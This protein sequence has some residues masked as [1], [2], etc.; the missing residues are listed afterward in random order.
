LA[1][2][3]TRGETLSS[4]AKPRDLC[5]AAPHRLARHF[6]APVFVASAFRRLFSVATMRALWFLAANLRQ[7]G[8]ARPS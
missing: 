5:F 7:R 3:P 4:R 8:D 6:P 1:S 2:R